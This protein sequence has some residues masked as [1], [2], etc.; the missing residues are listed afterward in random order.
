VHFRI[1]AVGKI[2][3]AYIE[4]TLR[5]FRNRIAPYH[6]LEELE[7]KAA[8]GADPPSAIA[9]EAQ[10]VL[11]LIGAADHLW[12]LERTGTQLSS[13]QLAAKLADL[14]LHGVSRLTLVVAGTHGADQRLRARAQ[15]LWSLSKLTLLHEGARALV[16][17]QLY[18]ATKI[19]RNEPYHH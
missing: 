1:V 2:R 7:V 12:L 5:D 4:E 17:E 11:K 15:F 6:R 8:S 3:E 9:G 18:R 13:E 19:E 10:G 16:L 14:A